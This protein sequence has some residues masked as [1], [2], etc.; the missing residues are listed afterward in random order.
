MK[1]GEKLFIHNFKMFSLAFITNKYAL[2]YNN[3]S[4]N[5]TLN[6]SV[7]L[8]NIVFLRLSVIKK[9]YVTLCNVEYLPN[10][11][12]KIKIKFSGLNFTS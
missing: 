12:K 3:L 1:K 5:I 11:K 6:C 7:I 2:L 8:K 10:I 4:I 9:H